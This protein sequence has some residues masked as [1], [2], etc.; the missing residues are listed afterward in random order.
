M[1]DHEDR[2]QAPSE[3]RRLRA[4]DSGEAPLSRELTTLA[5]LAAASLLMA[6]GLE[7]AA[8]ALAIRLRDQ[9]ADLALPPGAALHGAGL[10]LLRG[11]APLMLLVVLAS[12]AAVLLQTGFLLS[13]RRLMPD[14]G[15]I[16][17]R[18][19]LRRLFG[20]DNGIEAAKA[21]AKLALLA[22]IVGSAMATLWPVLPGTLL[23]T[24][25]RL[26]GQTASGI[27]H[28]MLLVLA[29]Q[30]GIAILD[31]GWTRWRFTQRMRMS[32][33]DLR[34]EAKESDGDPRIKAKYRQ[35]RMVRARRRMLAAVANATVVVTNPTHY[36][37][38][39]AYTRGGAGAPRV[40]AKGVDEVAAR[41]R[42]AADKAGVPLVA[43]PPLARALHQVPLDAEV[44]AEHFRMVAEIIAYVWRLHGLSAASRKPLR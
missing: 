3:R 1:S 38:A 18:R 39:L 16:D 31:T 5:G 12:A 26:A 27:L 34:Q 25:E 8:K 30:A 14:F 15:R 9:M 17:P 35:L 23:W 37:V 32:R 11:A 2:T 43:N 6:L 21:V 42:A 19:G 7:P 22:W 44:P 36:A 20:P 41:I 28:V 24:P 33:E 10:S 40:V 4:R 29:A 13:T